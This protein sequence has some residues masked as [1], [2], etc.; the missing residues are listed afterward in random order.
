MHTIVKGA[1]CTLLKGLLAKL[2]NKGSCPK[3]QISIHPCG[4]VRPKIYAMQNAKGPKDCQINK[5]WSRIMIAKQVKVL[6]V[7]ST[8]TFL[9]EYI[10]IS[11]NL[12]F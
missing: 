10:C 5:V 11:K 12:V 6:L 7:E 3:T 9:F 8:L 1:P 2:T 4:K